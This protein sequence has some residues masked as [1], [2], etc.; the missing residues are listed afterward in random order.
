[1]YVKRQG[2]ELVLFSRD[3][4]RRSSLLTIAGGFSSYFL[5]SHSVSGTRKCSWHMINAD[6]DLGKPICN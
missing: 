5:F 2:V 4:E 3:I 1:M 6:T